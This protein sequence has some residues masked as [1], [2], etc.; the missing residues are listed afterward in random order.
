MN[1]EPENDD[2]LKDVSYQKDIKG[3]ALFVAWRR[4]PV[5]SIRLIKRIPY[6]SK[7]IRG[8]A[9]KALRDE[10][11]PHI[12]KWCISLGPGG[13]TYFET[14]EEAARELVIRILHSAAPKSPVLHAAIRKD[15]EEVERLLES[16]RE[17]VVF[18]DV[19]D[20]RP[21]NPTDFGDT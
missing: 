11:R 5:G 19:K 6:I 8:E 10:Y 15:F 18:E 21:S 4:V 9:R 13:D 20:G 3:T 2:I 16:I 7:A 17:S 12:G 14:K 1:N